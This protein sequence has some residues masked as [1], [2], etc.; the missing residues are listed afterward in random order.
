MARTKDKQVHEGQNHCSKGNSVSV[1]FKT[2]ML[3]SPIPDGYSAAAEQAAKDYHDQCESYDRAI[4]GEDGRPK[5]QAQRQIISIHAS[6]TRGFVL[7]K[8]RVS[9]CDFRDALRALRMR[10]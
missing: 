4:C 7:R 8:Y 3:C 6:V 2:E 9:E 1:L 10:K 5:S